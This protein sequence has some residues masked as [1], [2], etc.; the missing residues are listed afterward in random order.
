MKRWE[1]RKLWLGIGILILLSPL[2]LLLPEL[3]HAGSAWGEWGPEELKS[4]AGRLPAQLA[5]W[6][7]FWKGLLPDYQTGHEQSTWQRLA[8]YFVSALLG[9]GVVA[10]ASFLL[11]KRLARG[12]KDSPR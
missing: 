8:A 4:I 1:Q 3:F 5:Q 2:G 10:T 12:G 7:D 11:G 9:A 6:A